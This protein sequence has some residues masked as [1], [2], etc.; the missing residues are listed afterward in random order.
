MSAIDFHRKQTLP[1]LR[2][3]RDALLSAIADPSIHDMRRIK[4]SEDVAALNS[5]IRD[6]EESEK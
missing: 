5:F 2:A 6:T 4:L 1:E 3:H